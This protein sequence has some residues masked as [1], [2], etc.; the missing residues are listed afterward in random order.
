MAD[1]GGGPSLFQA[2]HVRFDIKIDISID[3]S[4]Y[5]T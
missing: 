1:R 3:I 2:I 4:I 5:K